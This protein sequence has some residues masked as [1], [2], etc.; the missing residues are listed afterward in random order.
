MSRIIMSNCRSEV[1]RSNHRIICFTSMKCGR[2]VE[3]KSDLEYK[4][5]IQLEND[6]NVISY[7]EQPFTLEYENDRVVKKIS[8]DFLVHYRDGSRIVEKVM[9]LMQVARPE[10]CRRIAV[11]KKLLARHGYNFRVLTELKIQ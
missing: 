11:E 6:P 3:L 10:F 4:R 2:V 9:P 1:R 7:Q 8:L 5:A